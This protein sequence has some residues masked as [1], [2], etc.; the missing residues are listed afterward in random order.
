MS[1]VILRPEAKQDLEDLWSYIVTNSNDLKRANAFLDKVE[2]KL[3]TLSLQP[4]MGKPRN[5]IRA[6]LRSFAV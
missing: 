4:R 6:H 1:R 3:V 2:Q 5:E